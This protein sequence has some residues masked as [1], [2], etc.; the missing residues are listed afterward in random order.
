VVFQQPPY[1][2]QGY[3]VNSKSPTGQ[4][5]ATATA[6]GR[7]GICEDVAGEVCLFERDP[8]IVWNVDAGGK[9]NAKS[10]P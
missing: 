8:S 9:A 1:S 7:F 2:F 6:Q 5:K 10:T 3:L 4:R